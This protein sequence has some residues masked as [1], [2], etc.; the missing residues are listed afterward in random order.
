MDGPSDSQNNEHYFTACFANLI[1]SKRDAER[2]TIQYRQEM[3]STQLVSFFHVRLTSFMPALTMLSVSGSCTGMLLVG[4]SGDH[5]L[6]V[7]ATNGSH[8]TTITIP[9]GDQVHDAVWA[10]R[11]DNIVCITGVTR[12]ILVIGSGNVIYRVKRLTGQ[13][14]GV[15][16][17]NDML[18]I[19]PEQDIFQSRDGGM[20]W[21]LTIKKQLFSDWHFHHAIKLLVNSTL[22][23]IWAMQECC[24]F[25]HWK[26]RIHTKQQFW[27]GRP[28]VAKRHPASHG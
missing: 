28:T 26:L 18:L 23:V 19:T 10:S 15:S 24:L 14:L 5:Q 6:H 13:S 7:Y 17:D 11:N 9:N 2:T 16:A 1:S 3:T 27:R 20:T 8:V 21:R 4:G 22:H 25:K 12:S